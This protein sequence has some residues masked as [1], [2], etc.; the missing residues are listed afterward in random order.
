MERALNIY[1]RR[2]FESRNATLC[3]AA[4]I[5]RFLLLIS[6]EDI[7]LGSRS[8]RK[9]ALKCVDVETHKFSRSGI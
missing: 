5:T 7:S 9:I 8:S 6:Q 4:F 3:A 1:M 2:L